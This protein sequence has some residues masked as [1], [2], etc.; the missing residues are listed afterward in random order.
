MVSREGFLDPRRKTVM[1]SRE[2]IFC[3]L[4]E[5][6]LVVS[7]NTNF[8][9]RR[10]SGKKRLRFNDRRHCGFSNVSVVSQ[11]TVCDFMTGKRCSIAERRQSSK[12]K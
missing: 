9:G 4:A 10:F 11:S 1:L 7:P 6:G 5:G 12:L 3:G 8:S 2:G